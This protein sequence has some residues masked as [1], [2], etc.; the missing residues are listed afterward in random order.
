VEESLILHPRVAFGVVEQGTALHGFALAVAVVDVVAASLLPSTVETRLL[1]L[2]L[3]APEVLVEGKSA[4]GQ[5]HRVDESVPSILSGVPHQPI[6]KVEANPLVIW[7][8]RRQR[9][10]VEERVRSEAAVIDHCIG[11]EPYCLPPFGI[12]DH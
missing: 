6:P 4:F 12:N 3:R 7:R 1:Y 10:A 5:A 8:T 9:A 2:E 11:A